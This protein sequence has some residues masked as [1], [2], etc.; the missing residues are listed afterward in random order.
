[1]AGVVG[2]KVVDVLIEHGVHFIVIE[3]DVKKVEHL[4]EQGYNVIE[5]DATYLGHLKMLES[6]AQRL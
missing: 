1:M 4:K 2:Q 3:V 6:T 5:G